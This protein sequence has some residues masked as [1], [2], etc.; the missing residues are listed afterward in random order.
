MEASYLHQLSG[1]S[2]DVSNQFT[3]SSERST[4]FPSTNQLLR[5]N[6]QQSLLSR[7]SFESFYQKTN[8]PLGGVE[9]K[10]VDE[11]DERYLFKGFSR[12]FLNDR[13]DSATTLSPTGVNVELESVS[14]PQ[15]AQHRWL[16]QNIRDSEL[17][18]TVKT[19]LSDGELDREDML[20]IF[21]QAEDGDKVNKKEFRDMR[22]LVNRA[23]M[24]SMHD[25]VRVLS[26]KVVNGDYANRTY[27]G[28]PLGNLSAGSS[29]THLG[30][31]VDKWFFG[32][33]RPLAESYY[34]N[35][36]YR[37]QRVNKPLFH[38]GISYQD[39]Q[40]GGTGSCYLLAGLA[41]TA[42]HDP[43]KIRSMFID[44]GDNTYTVRFYNRNGKADYLTVDNA[45]PVSSWG[46]PVY[47]DYSNELWVALAEKAYAQLNESG[48]IG[49]S[50][51]GWDFRPEDDDTNSYQGISGGLPDEATEQITGQLMTWDLVKNFSPEAIINAF[52]SGHF[53]SFGSSYSKSPKIVSGHAYTLV[54]YNS[55]T[56]TFTLYNPWGIDGGRGAQDANPNDGKLELSWQ[57]IKNGFYSWYTSSNQMNV[58]SSQST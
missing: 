54:N 12:S 13:A 51:S 19:G 50:R 14:R 57:E 48:W 22:N 3:N 39:I 42:L 53:V 38:D 47:A 31:L 41:S 27:Q 18:S 37:Y 36:T 35:T 6:H 25:H 9:T 46:Q 11:L 58:K 33:D 34:G 49:H 45:L 55:N 2:D 56:E 24:L 4:I 20:A 30:K 8:S 15:P 32:G 10:S 29:A 23:S 26:R 7:S 40:Q 5:I 28:E 21:K 16:R 44:N 17:R 1:L 52:N 43:G